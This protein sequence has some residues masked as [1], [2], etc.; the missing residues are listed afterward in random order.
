M[1][2]LVF[3]KNDAGKVLGNAKQHVDALHL[4]LSDD[5]FAERYRNCLI[6]AKALAQQAIQKD[7]NAT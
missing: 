1:E 6:F 7:K 4:S 5:I 2:L 3:I